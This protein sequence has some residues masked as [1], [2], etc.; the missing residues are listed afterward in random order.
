LLTG[1]SAW[2]RP[3]G[4]V[5]L[6][7]LAT[8]VGLAGPPLFSGQSLLAGLERTLLDLRYQLRGDHP[9]DPRVVIVA[10][11]AKSLD[12]ERKP[13]PFPRQMHAQL[14]RFLT[15]A[16]ARVVA[17][18]VRF[19]GASDD[20][21]DPPLAAAFLHAPRPVA[22]VVGLE[23]DG[24]P[25][26]LAE[27]VFFEDGPRFAAGPILPGNAGREFG[28]KGSWVE[29]T[30]PVMSDRGTLDSFAVVA[31]SRFLGERRLMAPSRALIDYPQPSFRHYSYTK[32]LDHGVP[33]LAFRDKVVVIGLTAAELHDTSPTPL[34]D[35]TPG[36]DLQGAAIATALQRFPLQRASPTTNVLAAIGAGLL[37]PLLLLLGE[38]VAAY[39]SRGAVVASP[40]A[41][42]NDLVAGLGV[43]SLVS[44]CV[45]AQVAF[46][47]GTALNA[48]AG[49]VAIAVVAIAAVALARAAERRIYLDLRRRLAE[50]KEDL[51]ERADAVGS[52]SWP[53]AA[54]RVMIDGITIESRA[55]EGATGIVYRATQNLGQR[56]IA[57]KVVRS[58]LVASSSARDHF[59]AA[60]RDVGSV[61]HPNIVPV[62]DIA[63]DRGVLYVAMRW[64]GG[65]DLNDLPLPLPLAR[66]ATMVTRIADG[67]DATH[68]AGL[69]HGDIKPENVLM[70]A[71]DRD[72][73]YL[74]DFVGHTDGVPIGFTRE[75]A[76]PEAKAGRPVSAQSDVYSLAA[77]T[78][79]LLCGD[80]PDVTD[81]PAVSDLCDVPAAVGAVI[82]RAL[83][84]EPGERHQTA[85]AFAADLRAAVER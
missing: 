29:F 65:G 71:V 58:S 20:E 30:P 57:L 28:R 53:V 2:L 66:V 4:L 74:I 1:P 51:G 85:G 56:E 83:S 43:L 23:D 9:A 75:Y 14:L 26:P 37:L 31:A 67:L 72:H 45:I 63:E 18:D 25:A 21:N 8:V 35:A 32:V 12:G 73:P 38:A 16:G 34:N 69:L 48:S 10:V 68:A 76:S 24:L 52:E 78:F 39:R 80:P 70:D 19:P 54:L 50:G 79:F 44:W 13:Y 36:P 82:G 40:K 6:V 7:V 59:I 27:R 60:A 77:L 64:I 46:D 33:A 22:A 15:R 49:V 81:P 55:F 5:G 62:L 41:P 84:S 42:R 3:R 47:H 11:D 61:W 17:F